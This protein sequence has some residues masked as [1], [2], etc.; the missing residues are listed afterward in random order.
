MQF[1]WLSIGVM[2]V[3]CLPAATY[4]DSKACG[5]CH[6]DIARRYS[7]S[8]MANSIRPIERAAAIERDGV[9]N[10]QPSGKQYVLSRT[11]Q[12]RTT[13]DGEDAFERAVTHA[14]GSGK[15]ARSYLHRSPDGELTQFPL[16]WYTQENRWAM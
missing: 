12:R 4:I 6:P 15:N 10:H 5:A 13:T 2:Y 9:F 1:S 11:S 14:I 8:S 16:S 7:Q 3:A